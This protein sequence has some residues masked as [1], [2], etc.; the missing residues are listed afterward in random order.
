MKCAACLGAAIL[1]TVCLHPVTG[2]DDSAPAGNTP[3]TGDAAAFLAPYT[4]TDPRYQE[5]VLLF[6][7]GRR[8]YISAWTAG[9]G[10]GSEGIDVEFQRLRDAGFTAV[11]SYED[12]VWDYPG[13]G[14][15]ATKA[16]NEYGLHY[17]VKAQRLGNG[18]RGKRD[19]DN[20]EWLYHN[21]RAR[22][23]S[24]IQAV[25]AG[26]RSVVPSG[27]IGGWTH[28]ME[29]MG[30]HTPA[31]VEA[32]MF[33]QDEFQK[34]VGADGEWIYSPDSSA[35]YINRRDFKERYIHHCSATGKQIYYKEYAAAGG[36]GIGGTYMFR[37]WNRFMDDII[38]CE[39]APDFK[40]NYER[41]NLCLPYV[42]TI[43][44]AFA[45]TPEQARKESIWTLLC[46]WLSGC[47]G[48][49]FWRWNDPYDFAGF[50]ESHAMFKDQIYTAVSRVNQLTLQEVVLWADE[51]S[52]IT[53]NAPY[54][55]PEREYDEPATPDSRHVA[56]GTDRRR[57][58]NYYTMGPA[59]IYKTYQL[60]STRYVIAIN[61]SE[62]ASQ[63]FTL[64]G[65]P[66][67]GQAEAVVILEEG[68]NASEGQEIDITGGSVTCTL[69]TRGSIVFTVA[70][71]AEQCTE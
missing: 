34:A 58:V 57:N 49:S 51:K 25:V 47:K 52:D 19:K 36:K 65:F 60:D 39:Y 10:G 27:A 16:W 69:Q 23:V 42:G 32:L 1:A 35:Y 54:D 38:D 4:V 40:Y 30:N 13:G 44:Q 68:S 53:I 7:K 9:R 20:A 66:K 14:A 17:E 37:L 59:V 56:C 21:D 29:E 15:K 11:G 33:V 6:P 5:D 24:N 26:W 22:L 12:D 71:D 45:F 48:L 3:L 63:T 2:N 55:D 64:S 61:L 18:G 62:V 43:R 41:L 70:P 46:A 50:P 8:M 67:N 28:T 31:Y